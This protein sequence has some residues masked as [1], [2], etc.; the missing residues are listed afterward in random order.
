MDAPQA[1]GPIV[2]VEA[3]Q[4]ARFVCRARGS[5][6]A[7]RLEWLWRSGATGEPDQLLEP[8]AQVSIS[9]TGSGSELVFLRGLG[10]E[11]SGRALSCRA[12][13]E[14]LAA[15][16]AD[17][18]LAAEM[19]L[20]IKFGP[21]VRLIGEKLGASKGSGQREVGGAQPDARPRLRLA[22]QVQVGVHAAADSATV[23]SGPT[24][25]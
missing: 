23:D 11:F 8:G 2:G 3:G 14:H 10:P 20:D 9:G 13:N 16:R 19:V 25:A 4:T 6:P 12:T 24:A 18:S 17:R 22:C 15:G 5:R 21:L 7:A 1:A